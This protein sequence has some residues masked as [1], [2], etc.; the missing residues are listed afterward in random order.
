VVEE[1]LN[2]VKDYLQTISA[3]KEWKG[4]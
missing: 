3:D 2:E 1:K 4:L